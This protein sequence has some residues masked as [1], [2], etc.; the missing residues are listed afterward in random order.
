M[1]D[2]IDPAPAP[3]PDNLIAREN[4]YGWYVIDPAGGVWS[5][6][7]SVDEELDA[8]PP[9]ARAELILAICRRDCMRGE[10]CS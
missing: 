9:E 7:D 4:T 6:D 3:A 2:P 1:T 10:W 5:P 8:A